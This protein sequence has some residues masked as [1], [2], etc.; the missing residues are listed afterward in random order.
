MAHFAAGRGPSGKPSQ[1]LPINIMKTKLFSSAALAAALFVPLALAQNAQTDQ[2][3]SSDD[4]AAVAAAPAPNQTIYVPR[5]P[6]AQELSNAAA[7]QQ[8]MSIDRIEKT[9]SQVTVV[10]KFTNGQTNTVAYELLPAANGAPV[11]GPA[12]RV[13]TTTPPPTIVYRS[14]PRVVYYSDPYYS[15]YAYYPDYYW[16]PFSL[17]LGLGYVWHGGYHGGWHGDHD[18]WHGGHHGGWHGRR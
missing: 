12:P 9:D 4:S 10:Y 2:A 16:P 13:V 6:S 1:P 7:Q 8:G 5:L 14:S 11:T 15:P 18:G 3:G 17:S